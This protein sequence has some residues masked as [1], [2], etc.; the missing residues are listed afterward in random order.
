MKHIL[1][2]QSFLIHILVTLFH[3]YLYM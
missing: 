1:H 3:Y 2:D